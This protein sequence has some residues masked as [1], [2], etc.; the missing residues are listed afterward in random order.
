MV[1]QWFAISGPGKISYNISLYSFF[2]PVPQT[3]MYS[4]Q[5]HVVFLFIREQKCEKALG[6]D[7]KMRI[8]HSNAFI[9]LNK[10]FTAGE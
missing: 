5:K 4:V 10:D 9:D 8:P 1:H 6:S 3:K 2:L 7:V